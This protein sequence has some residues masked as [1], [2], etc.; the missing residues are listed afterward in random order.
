VDQMKLDKNFMLQMGLW[1]LTGV[2][3]LGLTIQNGYA[4]GDAFLGRVSVR[5]LAIDPSTPATL[6]AGTV[7]A[8]VFKS[9]NGGTSWTAVNT[10]L[11]NAWVTAL[12]IDPSTPATLYAGIQGSGVYK[13]TNGG[14]SWTASNTGGLTGAYVMALAIDPSTPAT[15]YAGSGVGAGAWKGIY[16]STNG[17]TSWTA[18]NTGLTTTMV[19]ALAIDRSTPATLYAGSYDAGVFKSTNGGANWG[20]VNSGFP[21]NLGN[22]V[23][24]YALAIDPS[25]PAT[26]YA[27]TAGGGVF[28]STNGGTSWTAVNSGLYDLS[29]ASLTIDPTAPA[30]LYAG[31]YYVYK[32]TNGGAFWQ[33]VGCSYTLSAA[34]QSV[35]AAQSTATVSVAT[36]NSVCRWDAVSNASWIAIT[37]GSMGT[38]NGTT[39]IQAAANTG[40]AR[41]GT[42]TIAGQTYTV[43][44][45]ASGQTGCSY[46]V[47][48]TSIQA[49][50]AGLSAT[51][52]IFTNAGCAWTASVP[53]GVNWITLNPA[54]GTGQGAV[55]YSI[56]ANTGPA[57]NAT[58]TVAT[59]PVTVA[60]DAASSCAYAL[61][62][63]SQL[64][65]GI[66]GIGTVTVTATGSNCSW[67]VSDPTVNWLHV[68]SPSSFTATGTVTYS[69]DPNPGPGKRSTTLTIA[70][71]TDTVTQDVPPCTYGLSATS[72]PAMAAT[73]GTGSVKV[74]ANGAACPWSA[75]TPT[76]PSL[77]WVHITSASSAA[78]S[79]NINYAVDA[80]TTTSAR[81][82]TL[83]ISGRNPIT[84]ISY[85]VN[86]APG[87]AN[88]GPVPVIGPSGI[89]NAAS[90]ISANLPAG[91]I[92][93]GSFFSI[94]GSGLGP[95]PSRS[96]DS[97]PLGTTL[98]NV[99]VKVTQGAT[100]VAAIPLF[101]APFQINAVMPSNVPTGTVQ[102]TVTYNG[103]TST[104]APVQVVASNFGAFSVSAGRG[105]GI[106]QNY[107]SP[108]QAPLNTS[109]VTAAPGD[110]V[111][112]W[113]TGLGPLPG[114]A[115]DSLPPAAGSLAVS[116][117]V[118]V[119]RESVQP[120]YSGRAPGLAGVDQI[121]FVIPQ[122]APLGCYVPIQVVAAGMASNVITMAIG[123]NRQP[124]SDSSPLG[125]LSRNGGKNASVA[126]TRLTFIN[127]TDAAGNGTVDLGSG[128]LWLK[129]PGGDLGFDLFSSLPPLNSCTYY[130]NMDSLN[131]VLAGAIPAAEAAA[132]SL[133]AGS[134]LTV[135]GPNGVR[136]FTYADSTMKTS[137][138]LGLLGASG[139]F[140]AL[141]LS[142]QPPFLDPGS[143]TV[144]GSGG[145]D[146]GPFSFA[147]N[148]PNPA[149]W[150][151]RDQISVIDRTQGL[152]VNW[153]GGN[154]STQMG[155][156]F[157][158]ASNPNTKVS[159]G[160]AC[161]ASLD[162]RTFTVPP[163]MMA[164]LPSTVGTNP[165]N[166]QSLLLFVTGPSGDQFVKFNTTASPSLDNGLGF[167]VV[168]DLLLNVTYK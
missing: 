124:C 85:T 121:N 93:Q 94:F 66:S 64:I 71:Q 43:N 54:S 98:G 28:K 142:S 133:D 143:Y 106:V 78:G 147:L 81:S 131:G 21:A 158:F 162:Q 46:N 33:V 130:N 109:G 82:V 50:A 4:Q 141:G 11:G 138:Y 60:Q 40:A 88:T 63:S 116:V 89:V 52:V 134:T 62:S 113:G 57:R 103:A 39:A 123:A 117:R 47:S 166:I 105:P 160:F 67:T 132:Q 2:L 144:S 96:A 148:I 104:T 12:A 73:G 42:L 110:T 161:V 68:T 27:G 100:S 87:T 107:V 156:I 65:A 151:N 167:F 108:T 14:T 44:Q 56:A 19:Y 90:F 159:G 48:P 24:V 83:T 34:S 153:I 99:S 23:Y 77:Q 119:G 152:T 80:N 165:G 61:S 5:S 30:T 8:G 29:I 74:T 20:A 92:A 125:T 168:G 164:N 84:Q 150:T 55:G 53:A 137:P 155:V 101:V 154:P 16:K 9:T 7:N 128:V 35:G 136:G 31:T 111:I 25:T 45:A 129:P 15:L 79:G 72:S 38:G 13:S 17:G 102:V 3:A 126:L 32:S 139:A 58:L 114:G 69:V 26:V 49:T 41:T 22:A 1:T 18:V 51:M 115:S 10:G 122:N 37:S 127:L 145:K 118:S 70:N 149:T 112:L 59:V 6:Y 97:Y 146:V 157:G 36:S 91:A 75:S 86:Q 135:K 140:A 76:E 95:D 163:G 120:V